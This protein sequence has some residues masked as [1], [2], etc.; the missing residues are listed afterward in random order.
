MKLGVLFSGGKDSTYAAY[1][2][3]KEGYELACLI[4]IFSQ[5][6][7]SYMFHTP[8]I[9]LVKD[10]AKVMG[11]PLVTE[12]TKGKK[13][14]ELVDL[15]KAIKMAKSKY[16]IEGI[17]T[18]AIESIYQSSRIQ[19]ICF[20][21]GLKCFNPL[22]QKDQLEYLKELIKAKFKVI[23]IG[24]YAYPLD[25]SWLGRKI[26]KKFIKDVQELNQKYKINPSGEGG[27]FE[28]LVL[29]CPL[30]EKPL[31]PKSNYI[32]GSDNSWSLKLELK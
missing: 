7:E 14:T 18:G 15:E 19:K 26:D 8:N 23:I 16:K 28:T 3:K 2:A 21:L 25:E 12:K 9:K 11:L 6:K 31:N 4:S 30:F 5:N 27:E 32:T 20:K 1:M 22:W 10:Q 13:E 29:D 17:V 24:V